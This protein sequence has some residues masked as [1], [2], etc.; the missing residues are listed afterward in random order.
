MGGGQ[1]QQTRW[2]NCA[3]LAA[4]QTATASITLWFAYSTCSLAAQVTN[5]NGLQ[6][7][8]EA[9]AGIPDEAATSADKQ[10]FMTACQQVRLMAGPWLL[11]VVRR[12]FPVPRGGG[13]WKG[14]ARGGVCQ[15]CCSHL[16]FPTH[17]GAHTCLQVVAGG[18]SQRDERVLQQAVDELSELCRRNRRAAQLA[19]RALLPPELHY[20]IR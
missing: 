4:E 18:L 3:E 8:G 14:S 15:L 10:R 12:W 19:Q 17:P 1:Q 9:L 6:W 5:Q 7:V 11:A 13:G 20:T 2:A 16:A